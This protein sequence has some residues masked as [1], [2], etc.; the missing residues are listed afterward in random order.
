M[1]VNIDAPATGLAAPTPTATS[2]GPTYP[3]ARLK[4]AKHARHRC[5]VCRGIIARGM[6][7]SLNAYAWCCRHCGDQVLAGQA[8]VAL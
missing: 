8:E 4:Y 3:F 1:T 7:W 2:A 5:A 6:Y